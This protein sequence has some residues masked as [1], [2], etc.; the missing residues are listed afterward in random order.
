M[1]SVRP[2][3]LST[4]ENIGGRVIGLSSLDLL[5]LTGHLGFDRVTPL[6]PDKRFLAQ[7]RATDFTI[8]VVSFNL[9]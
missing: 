6:T 5:C 2:L 1:S 3:L 9:K 7:A 4:L 8:A